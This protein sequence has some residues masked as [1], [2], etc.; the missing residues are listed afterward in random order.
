MRKICIVGAGVS[1]SILAAELS[2]NTNDSITLLDCDSLN[3]DFN[4][5]LDLKKFFFDNYED[6]K[7]TGYGFGG[8]SNLWHGVLTNLDPEDYKYIKE[9][10]NLDLN[11]E[12]NILS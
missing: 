9:N 11:R 5:N 6:V 4:Y 8:S 7:T 2:Q 10:L 12:L 1:G 3:N